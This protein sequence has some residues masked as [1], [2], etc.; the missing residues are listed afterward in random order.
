MK[1]I[2]TLLLLA[3]ALSSC[4]SLFVKLYNTKPIIDKKVT[5]KDAEREVIFIPMVHVSKQEYYDQVKDFVTKKRQD[6]Y[7]IYYE[8]VTMTDSLTPAQRD[9]VYR[10]ARKVLGF[11]IKGAYD[12][13]SKNRSFVKFK[14]YVG[15]SRENTGIDTLQDVRLDMALDKLIPLVGKVGGEDAEIEL[16]DCDFATPLNEKYK[17]KKP[18]LWLE[19]RYALI[20]GLRNDYITETLVKAPHKKIVI[21]YGSG[22]RDAIK[23]AMDKLKLEKVK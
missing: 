12:K 1:K 19:Y 11:H 18:K 16:D 15:Q 21:L 5:W 6:G 10:K 22:H 2:T 23:Q 3:F 8:G 4:N 7:A 17:C 9:T 20:Y 13:N 14:R